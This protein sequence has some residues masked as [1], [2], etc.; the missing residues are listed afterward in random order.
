M[1][2]R[3]FLQGLSA[4]MADMPTA[5]HAAETCTPLFCDVGIPNISVTPPQQCQQWCWA[6]SIQ[7]IFGLHGHHVNQQVIVQKLFGGLVCAPATNVQMFAAI[8]GQ[9]IDSNGQHFFAQTDVLYDPQFGISRPNTLSI[10]I[11]ELRAGNPMINGAVGHATVLTAI[12]YANTPMG[13]KVIS[14][15][16]RDPWPLNPNKRLLT[17]HE[18]M[19]A[20]F[21]ARV[22]VY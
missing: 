15:T 19:G 11:N 20:S 8:N 13:P 3:S 22:V 9:W 10:M 12:R 6:A 1:D 4:V 16:V 14:A 2:R 7:A 18:M 17:P 5:L 21:I